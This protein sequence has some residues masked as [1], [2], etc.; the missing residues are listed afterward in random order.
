MPE[1]AYAVVGQTAAN[2]VLESWV[3]M[4]YADQQAA[5]AH[6]DAANAEAKRI[7]GTVKRVALLRGEAVEPTL[8]A[9]MLASNT[10]DP[11][12]RLMASGTSYVAVEA[13]LAGGLAI[14]QVDEITSSPVS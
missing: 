3:V 14:R 4:I 8:L 1:K 6:A 9:K 7:H 5:Q 13:P 11:A 2:D 10:H 12:M